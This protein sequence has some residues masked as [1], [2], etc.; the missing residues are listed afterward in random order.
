MS[1]SRASN[2]IGDS[3]ASVYLS[4]AIGAEMRW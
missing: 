2:A 1:D 4:V 3:F